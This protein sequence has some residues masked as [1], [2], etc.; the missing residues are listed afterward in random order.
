LTV[1]SI[2]ATSIWEQ[3]A[4]ALIAEKDTEKLVQT[5][6]AL[7]EERGDYFTSKALYDV[8]DRGHPGIVVA[9]LRVAPDSFPKNNMSVGELVNDT[10]REISARDPESFA[11]VITSF[12]PTDIKLFASIRFRTLIRNDAMDVLKGIMDKSSELI[13]DTLPSWLAFHTF[14]RGSQR[15]STALEGSFQYLAS[16]ATESVL[17]KALSIVQRNEH[18]K[19]DYEVWCCW[20]QDDFPQALID[21]LTG[22]L[23]LMKARN[24]L[25][26]KTLSFMP[27][28]LLKLL[29]EYITC[30]TIDSP[31]SNP[32][33]ITY[34]EH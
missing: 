8:A 9:C 27:E 10:I 2:M 13:I 6:Q 34:T 1:P 31:T 28:V 14:D 11:K 22:L 5:F 25:V 3:M 24:E 32:E 15:Y 20:H 29:A 26:K 19:V 21:K 4:N 17:E 23:E 7:H 18:H 12:K 33:T 16:F 30:E